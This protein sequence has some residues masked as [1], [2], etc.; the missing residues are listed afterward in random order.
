MVHEMRLELT[1]A[2]AHYPLTVARLPIPPFM[3]EETKS[4]I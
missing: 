3:H 4:F 2:N 1:R